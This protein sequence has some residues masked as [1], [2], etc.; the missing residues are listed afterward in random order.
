MFVNNILSNWEWDIYIKIEICLMPITFCS[1]FSGGGWKKHY[2]PVFSKLDVNVWI[3]S[4]ERVKRWIILDSN[5]LTEI[6]LKVIYY[7]RS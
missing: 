4:L 1:D 7:T 6:S 2:F 3:S 5:I